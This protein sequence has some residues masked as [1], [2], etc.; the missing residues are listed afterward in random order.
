MILHGDNVFQTF[1][2]L[3][4]IARSF[5]DRTTSSS[6]VCIARFYMKTINVSIDHM[7]IDPMC[8]DTDSLGPLTSLMDYFPNLENFRMDYMMSVH[9]SREIARFCSSLV[10]KRPY[11]KKIELWRKKDSPED[12]SFMGSAW[13]TWSQLD[14]KLCVSNTSESAKYEKNPCLLHM[15]GGLPEVTP[16]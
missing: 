3:N 8:I 4:N 2:L 10:E 14:Y 11:L 1:N 6:S 15:M 12:H 7:C 16:D 9:N 13:M 5:D